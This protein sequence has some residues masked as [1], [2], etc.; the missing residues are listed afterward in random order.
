MSFIQQSVSQFLLVL[1]N[2]DGWLEKATAY[3]T[4]KSF[5]PDN[6]VNLRLAPDQFTLTRQIQSACDTAKF[7][8]ARLAGKE[9]PSHPDTEK[10]LA[11]LRERV[12]KCTSYLE[13]LGAA[14]FAGAEERRISAQWMQGKW[15]S[16]ADYLVRFGIP[17]FYFHV[18]TTY[19]ILR[20]NGVDVGK[21]D[22]LG[23]V[24][25]KD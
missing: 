8:A 5:E 21:R 25:L 7:T 1:R 22:F 18:T 24:D 4:Q 15:L 16:G 23:P 6:F 10:T 13:S 2:M 9:A 11:E 17:N 19:A 20:H 14:D 3:A 12:N